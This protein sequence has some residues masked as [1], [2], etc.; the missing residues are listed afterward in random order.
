[1]KC[2]LAQ[3][4]PLFEMNIYICAVRLRASN[5]KLNKRQI[6]LSVNKKSCE[7]NSYLQCVVQLSATEIKQSETGDEI[8]NV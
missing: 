7:T 5:C 6:S 4:A 3:L 1:M 8:K 2:S